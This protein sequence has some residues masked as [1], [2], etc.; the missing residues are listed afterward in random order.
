MLIELNATL[1]SIA[2]LA[3]K[4]LVPAPSPRPPHA[5]LSPLA[6][7]AGA[8]GTRSSPVASGQ[9]KLP[10][11]LPSAAA[12]GSAGGGAA[13]GAACRPSRSAGTALD[14]ADAP[15][16]PQGSPAAQ[17]PHAGTGTA[18]SLGAGVGNGC[19]G[20]AQHSTAAS[21]AVRADGAVPDAGGSATAAAA[22]G[23]GG[24]V[25]CDGAAAA[26][27]AADACAVP[28]CAPHEQPA[29]RQPR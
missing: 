18:D 9:Q 10:P 27:C 15:A 5:A 11:P 23:G 19:T 4:R 6:A 12:L 16:P 25:G 8:G 2:A 3:R 7:G 24:G 21:Q 22:S 14:A 20:C 17:V 1:R 29:A 26:S 28:G 13:V